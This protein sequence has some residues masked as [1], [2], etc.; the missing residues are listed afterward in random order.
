MFLLGVTVFATM[1][2]CRGPLAQGQPVAVDLQSETVCQ[3]GSAAFIRERDAGVRFLRQNNAAKALPLLEAA[4]QSCPLDYDT[5]RDLATAQIMADNFAQAKSIIHDLLRQRDRPELHN[6]LARIAT[7]KKDY[8]GAAVEYQVAATMDPTENNIFNF[9]TALFRLDYASATEIL[10]YGLGKFP[11]SIKLRVALATALY[12]QGSSQEGATLLCEAGE[13]A[14]SD[15]HPME[16]LADT[17]L[18]PLSILPRAVNLMENLRRQ[19]P[20]DGLILYD[21]IMVKSKRWSGDTTALPEDFIH[22]LTLA[23]T[24]NPKIPQAYYSLALAYDLKK[25]YS[26]EIAALRH[27]VELDPDKEQYHYRLAFAYRASGN[28]RGFRDELKKYQQ[29]HEKFSPVK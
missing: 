17:E 11:N 14:P 24:L 5:S 13:L 25:L 26:K 9:G 21:Y 29:L 27:A 8:R 10:R 19:Y 16:V 15:P 3:E 6:L 23:L 28:M 7:A 1:L 22:S 20:D 12:A 18:V 2:Y 4:H